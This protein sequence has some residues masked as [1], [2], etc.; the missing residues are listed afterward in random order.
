L[1]PT[2]ARV[3]TAT[4]VSHQVADGGGEGSIFRRAPN[5]ELL[6]RES[7]T[8][9]ATRQVAA[10]RRRWAVLDLVVRAQGGDRDAFSELASRSLG[11]MTGAAR[12]ILRDEYAAQDAVQE[13]FIEAWRSLPGLR[14]PERFEAW[15]RK[16]LVRACF[17]ALRRTKRVDAVEIRLTPADEPAT[18]GSDRNLDVHDQLERGLAKLPPEQRAVVVLVYYL[19]LPLA[20]AAQAMGI[21]IGTTKSRLNRA[22]S[23]LRAVLEADERAPSRVGEQ[24]A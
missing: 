1:F 2:N 16:L 12:M 21:P 7:A 4:R 22:T 11:R 10:P 23:A 15:T 8:S 9:L 5:L 18:L 19:D 3:A 6:D 13:A 14:D 24:I 20:E 17:K